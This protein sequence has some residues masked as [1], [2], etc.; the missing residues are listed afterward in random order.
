[1]RTTPKRCDTFAFPAN[2][3]GFA[4]GMLLTQYM[5]TGIFL[6]EQ[7]A[8]RGVSTNVIASLSIANGEPFDSHEWRAVQTELSRE[9]SCH[10][11]LSFNKPFRLFY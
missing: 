10:L 3:P 4:L 1:M 11:S 2:Q 8:F 5:V 6:P 7:S 9:Q